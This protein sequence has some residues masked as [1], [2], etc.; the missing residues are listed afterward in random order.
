MEKHLESLSNA[1]K[2]LRIADHIVYT[3]YPLIK[4]KRLLLKALD[5]IY[6]SIIYTINSILQYDYLNKKII[7]STN[8]KENFDTFLNKSAKTYNISNQEIKELVEFIKIIESHKK[9]SMEFTRRE[10]IIILSENLKTNQLD[11][12][13]MRKYLNLGKRMLEKTKIIV[14]IGQ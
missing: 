2:K 3:T 8:P 9:S 5:S 13:K 14:T 7:L 1:I 12:E 4:D 10:K 6:E 11:L